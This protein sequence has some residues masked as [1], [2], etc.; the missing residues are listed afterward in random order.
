M[1]LSFFATNII[2]L[3]WREEKY[4]EEEG[5]LDWLYAKNEETTKGSRAMAAMGGSSQNP[6]TV[7]H[8]LFHVVH[9]T[10]LLNHVSLRNSQK[11]FTPVIY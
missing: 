4:K 8:L 2:S 11:V 3:R 1:H 10:L 6:E 7:A 5:S 9:A